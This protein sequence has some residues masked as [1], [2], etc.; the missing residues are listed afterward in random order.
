VQAVELTAHGE[1]SQVLRLT[2]RPDPG[3]PGSHE[4][5]LE[6]VASPINP[7]DLL[8]ARGQYGSERQLPC[9]A[10]M[11]GACRVLAVGTAVGHLT[12]GDLVLSPLGEVWQQ[13]RV[14]A[15]EHL[16]A[17]PRSI[18]PEQ[19][20]MVSINP[21]TAALMLETVMPLAAGDWIIQSGASSATGMLIAALACECGLRSVNLVRR[22]QSAAP[23]KEAGGTTVLVE[24]E[25]RGGLS[26]LAAA[27]RAATEGA[28]IRFALDCIA[29]ATTM[30]LA[31]TLAPGGVLVVYGGMSGQ[32]SWIAPPH[33]IFRD[34][35]LRGFW[36]TRALAAL[37][38]ERRH[39]VYDRLIALVAA[40][41]LRAEVAARYPLAAIG[42]ALAR[43][44][45]SPRGGKVLLTT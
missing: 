18:D 2:E 33:L 30:A 1:P 37:A 44:A 27:A 17:L 45:A 4:A 36:L 41:K 42:E 39:A 16:V 26:G 6:L 25:I 24:G 29:G 38:P 15:A 32:P 43:N 3:A 22:R 9:V 21:A 11:E 28:P 19:A 23:V 12:A 20:A 8:D 13:R 14:V 10:G 40:G 31:S 7:A 5:L 34:L 35:T